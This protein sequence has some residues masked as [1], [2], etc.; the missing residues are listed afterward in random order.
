MSPSEIRCCTG[1]R[2]YTKAIILYL[3]SIS[4]ITVLLN[5]CPDRVKG[6]LK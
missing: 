2:S 1:V 5:I 4:N 6:L 3:C